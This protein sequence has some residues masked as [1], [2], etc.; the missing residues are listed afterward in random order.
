MVDVFEFENS[1]SI[2]LGSTGLV[3][4]EAGKRRIT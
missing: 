4:D 3:M 1:L 2:F